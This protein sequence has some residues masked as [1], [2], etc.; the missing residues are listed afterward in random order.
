[1]RRYASVSRNQEKIGR[2]F[3]SQHLRYNH[4]IRVTSVTMHSMVKCLDAKQIDFFFEYDITG[5][6][7]EMSRNGN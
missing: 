3:Q 4:A 6:R 2:T 1:M 7:A 5:G